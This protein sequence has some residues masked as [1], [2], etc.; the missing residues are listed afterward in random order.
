MIWNYFRLVPSQV[1][2]LGSPPIADVL[3]GFPGMSRQSVLAGGAGNKAHHGVPQRYNKD[4]GRGIRED[5]SNAR[6]E[7][8]PLWERRRD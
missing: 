5:G 3:G 6:C 1:L 8:H 7:H 4:I 2:G